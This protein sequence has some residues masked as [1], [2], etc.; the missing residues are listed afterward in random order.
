MAIRKVWFGSLGPFFYDDAVTVMDPDGVVTEYQAGVVVDGQITVI[1]PPV[2][3]TDVVRLDDLETALSV[4]EEGTA[5]G[6]LLYWDHVAGAWKHTETTEIVWDDTNKRVGI[7]AATPTERLEVGGNLF[8]SADNN[9]VLLG[10]GKD[11]SI[12]YNGTDGYIKTDEVAPSDLHLTTGA[13]KTLV[14]D[15]VVYEDLNFDPTRSGGPVATRPDDVLIGGCYYSEFTSA[16]NQICG[17]TAEYPHPGKLGVNSTPHGHAFLKSGESAGTTGVEFTIYWRLSE[18]TGTTSGSVV[19]SATSAE[20]GTTAGANNLKMI[21]AAF[22]GPTTFS[23][24]LALTIART[25]GDAGD[26]VLLTY[27]I[28]YQKDTPGSRTISTK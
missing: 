1:N 19:V 6:Q 17:S 18:T 20:L 5:N 7:N 28:H 8:L 21:G 16:N 27:G 9:K 2:A 4:L 15:T 14:Y 22:A 13:A 11:L 10:A 26:V 23:A 3:L 24:Q 12:Y 25:G